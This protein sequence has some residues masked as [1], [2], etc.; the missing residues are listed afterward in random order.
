MKRLILSAIFAF[1]AYS[2]SAIAQKKVATNAVKV[3]IDLNQ[4]KNDKVMVTITPPT[5][6][7]NEVVFHFP[8]T[9][10]GTYSTDNYGKL[11]DNLKA[12]DKNGN[13]L[14]TSKTDD[15]SWNIP[16][17]KSVAKITY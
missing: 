7:K 16:N 2:N 17:A 13:E 10:P 8:K 1:S 4:V 14:V 9:V 6:T 3:T 12:F 15:N 5:F 11:V